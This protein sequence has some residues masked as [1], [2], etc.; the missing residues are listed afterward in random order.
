MKF[1]EIYRRAI[2]YW[3]DEVQVG[4]GY[5]A[6][7]DGFTFPTLSKVW[8]E[9]EEAV[10]S[11]DEWS[12]LAVWCMFQAFHSE[13]RRLREMG[14]SILR[15][16]KVPKSEIESRISENLKADEWAEFRGIYEN[17]LPPS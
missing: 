1:S 15:P 10:G 8:D 14:Q 16:R 6:G 2:G 17:D 12:S 5:P 4:D 9:A 7:A 13:S 3:P 11:Q